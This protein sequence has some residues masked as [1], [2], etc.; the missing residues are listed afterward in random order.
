MDSDPSYPRPAVEDSY[1]IEWACGIAAD[2]SGRTIA[3]S[4]EDARIGPISTLR[5]L[6]R[7]AGH[8]RAPREES[9]HR[10]NVRA[11]NPRMK[12]AP[13]TGCERAMPMA[14]RAPIPM[15]LDLIAISTPENN[16]PA[17]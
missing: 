12:A 1:L 3:R 16:R 5:Q 14:P 4:A 6:W 17:P 8:F 15:F 10:F 2:V 9:D 13:Y 7:N 11:K